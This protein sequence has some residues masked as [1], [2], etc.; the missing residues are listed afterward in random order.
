MVK[1]KLKILE[2]KEQGRSNLEIAKEL[3]IAI[4]TVQYWVNPEYR[5]K[6]IERNKEAFI[7][8]SGNKKKELTKQRRDYQRKYQSNRYKND[9]KFR[10]QHIKRVIRYQKNGRVSTN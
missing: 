10:E 4:S 6:S 9:P 8:L 5:I 2:L 7:K 1:H 3:K